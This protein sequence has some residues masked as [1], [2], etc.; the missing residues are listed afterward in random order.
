MPSDTT[1]IDILVRGHA[2]TYGNDAD[3]QGDNAAVGKGEVIG[4]A[5]ETLSNGSKVVVSGATF[6][7]NFEMDGLDY[8]NYQISEKVLKNLLQLQNLKLVKL[9][10]LE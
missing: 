2:T 1:N 7:S 9:L 8:S 6:F 4:L 3:K 10:M 5:V